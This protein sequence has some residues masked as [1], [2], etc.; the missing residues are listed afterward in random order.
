MYC[1]PARLRADDGQSGSQLIFGSVPTTRLC[2]RTKYVPDGRL[3]GSQKLSRNAFA[4]TRT[5]SAP[6]ET[7]FP[8]IAL[9]EAEHAILPEHSLSFTPSS[10]LAKQCREWALRFRDSVHF[11]GEL[12]GRTL[13]KSR[14][15]R[16]KDMSLRSVRTQ[17]SAFF[18]FDL[19]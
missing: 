14:E 11:G 3:G 2:P 13:R 10:D 4:E 17:P 12:R 1:T 8:G 9:N 16:Q 19:G 18:A 15:N 5:Q 6:L 7:S